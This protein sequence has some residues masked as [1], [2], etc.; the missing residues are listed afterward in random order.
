MVAKSA[1]IKVTK[2]TG[3]QDGGAAARAQIAKTIRK[4][5]WQNGAAGSA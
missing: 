3:K 2:T 1:Y 5:I 4:L